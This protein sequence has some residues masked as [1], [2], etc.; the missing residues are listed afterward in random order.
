LLLASLLVSIDKAVRKSVGSQRKKLLYLLMGTICVLY[1]VKCL[2][3][4]L[5]WK[6][7]ENLWRINVVQTPDNTKALH[8]WGRSL[9]D[10]NRTREAIEHYRASVKVYPMYEDAQYNL[11]HTLADWGL[12]NKNE[13]ALEESVEA[14][15][16]LTKMVPTH[17]K[18]WTNLANLLPHLKRNEEAVDASFQGL[19][20]APDEYSRSIGILNMGN[21]LFGLDQKRDAI[22]SY[23]TVLRL[24]PTTDRAWSNMGAVLLQGFNDPINALAAMARAQRLAPGDPGMMQ[25]M[26]AI[27]NQIEQMGGMDKLMAGRRQRIPGTQT[28][29]IN[30]PSPE[31]E[32]QRAMRYMQRPDVQEIVKDIQTFGTQLHQVIQDLQTSPASAQKWMADP[33]IRKKIELMFEAGILKQA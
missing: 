11:A 4:N 32:E 19:Q 33:A 6:S 25:N 9:A 16:T 1:S 2:F 12:A 14:Y 7:D 3:R 13:S 27:R 23:M 30:K 24:Q 29:A 15:Y 21:G 31:T 20:L 17:Y 18:S 10:K 28:S 22:R 26:Q 5:D 8:N